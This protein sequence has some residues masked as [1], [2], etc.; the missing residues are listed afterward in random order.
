VYCV[1]NRG[2]YFALPQTIGC[3]ILRAFC[4]GWESRPQL[5]GARR[6][7]KVVLVISLPGWINVSLCDA[8]H[9]Q[10]AQKRWSGCSPGLWRLRKTLVPVCPGL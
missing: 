8:L 4:E 3:P 10:A 2:A 5:A 1:R 9:S 7:T 6:S